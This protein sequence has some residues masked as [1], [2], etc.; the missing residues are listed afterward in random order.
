MEYALGMTKYETTRDPTYAQ[1]GPNS[2]PASLVLGM[3]RG[4]ACDELHLPLRACRAS[5]CRVPRR[6]SIGWEW[7]WGSRTEQRVDR[8]SSPF[9]RHWANIFGLPSTSKVSGPG[10]RCHKISS[11][12]Y[13][14]VDSNI[15]ALTWSEVTPSG[16]RNTNR[17]G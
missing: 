15:H 11:T 8:G 3:G 12:L 10:D 4:P 1:E 14:V 9:G 16:I 5:M 7:G 6:P 17:P 13:T 2:S